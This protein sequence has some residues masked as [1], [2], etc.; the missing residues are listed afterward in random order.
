M[1]TVKMSANHVRNLYEG[2]NV[3]TGKYTY[4]YHSSLDKFFRQN[5]MLKNAGLDDEIEEV[6]VVC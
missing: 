2:Y 6:K 3:V 4:W 1:K 5:T